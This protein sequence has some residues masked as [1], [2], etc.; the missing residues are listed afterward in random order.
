MDCR[1]RVKAKSQLF[2]FLKEFSHLLSRG[3]VSLYLT[4]VAMNYGK[5]TIRLILIFSLYICIGL[6]Q[7]AKAAITYFGSSSNPADGGSGTSQ[8][9]AV[10]PPSNM[11]VGDLVIFTGVH[12]SW[13][14]A[15]DITISNT[16]GQSWTGLTM[17]TEAY[18]RSRIFYAR[19]DGTW[20]AN[21]SIYFS[22]KSW[23]GTDSMGVIMHVFRPTYTCKEWAMDVN[24]VYNE[25]SDDPTVI[26]GITTNTNGALVFAEWNSSGTGTWGSLTSG[27]STPG[28]AQYRNSGGTLYGI[29]A[30][31]AYKVQAT[32]GATGNVSKDNSG[33]QDG[34][35]HIMAFKE[36]TTLNN[37]VGDGTDPSNSTIAPGTSATEIDRFTLQASSGTDTI[38]GATVTLGPTGAYNNIATVAIQNTAGTTTYCTT[39]TITSNTVSMTCSGF[40][41]TTTSTAYKIMITPKTHASMPAV[42]G[43]SYATTAT[44]TG[45]TECYNV[46]GSDTDSATITV[47]NA[48]PGAVTSATAYADDGSVTLGWTNPTDADFTTGGTTI[49]LRR[50]GSAISDTPVEGTTY[51]VG[52]TIGSSTVMAVYTGS[53]P[54]TGYVNSSLTNGTVYYYKIFTQDSRGNYNAGTSPTGSP[55]SPRAPAEFISVIDPGNGSGTDYTS[56]SVWEST[57]QA[58]ITSNSVVFFPGT[59]TGTI[60]NGASVTGAT[61]GATGT[62]IHANAAG[63][64]IMLTVTSGFFQSGE[65][66]RVDASNYFTT[67]GILNSVIAIAKCRTTTA[68]ADTTAVTLDGWTTRSANYIKIWT[69]TS[70]N[71]RHPGNWD[72]SKYRLEVS[73][74][75]AIRI[76]EEYTRI[77]GLQIQ[78]SDSSLSYSGIV[79]SPSTSTTNLRVAG[80]IIKGDVSGTPQNNAGIIQSSNGTSYVWNNVVYGFQYGIET[81]TSGSVMYAYNNTVY[82]NHTGI[83]NSTASAITLKNSISYKNIGTDYSGTFNS[84][85][86]NNLSEDATVPNIGTYYSNTTVIFADPENGDFHLYSSDTGAKN[87]GTSSI[88]EIG[89]TV[90]IDNVTRN[91]TWD[92]GADEAATQV[93]YSVGQNNDDHKTGS[94]TVTISSGVA[95]FS[96]AQTAV[97]MGVG[98]KVTYNTSSVAYISKKI[99]DITWELVTA[100]GSAPADVSGQTVNSIAHTFSSLYAAEDGADDASY[101]NTSNLVS[102]NYQLNISCYYDSGADATAVTVDGWTTG[103]SNYIRIYTPNNTLSEVNQSQ[104]H[105]GSLNTARYMLQLSAANALTISEEYVRVDGL[106]IQ[107]T[108]T[109]STYSGIIISPATSVANI[110]ISNNII[111]GVASGTAQNSRGIYQSSDGTSY[112]WNNIVHGFKNGTNTLYGIETNSSGSV[113][114]A[115]NNTAYGN[116]IGLYPAAGTIVAKNNLSYNNT[117]DY[118]GTFNSASTNNLSKDATVPNLGTYYASATVIFLNISLEDYRLS[119]DDTGAKDRGADLGSGFYND[120]D[121]NPRSSVWDIGADE[122]WIVTFQSEKQQEEGNR[123]GLI[124]YQSF[125]GQDISGTKAID[126]SGNGYDGTISGA[127]AVI[128]KKGQ[129]L[130]FDGADDNIDAGSDFIGI[131]EGTYSAWIFPESIG[132]TAG[133]IFDNGKTFISLGTNIIVFSSDGGTNNSQSAVSSI[134]YNK[135]SF[136]S[137]TRDSSGLTN[138][139]IDGVL[140]GTADQNSGTPVAGTS[141]VFIGNTSDA[142]R[143]FDGII[144]EVRIYSRIL[145]AEE[146]GDL[147]RLGEAKINSPQATNSNNGLILSQSFDGRYMDWS[148]SSAEARDASGNAHH[149]DVSG[150]IATIGR[151][152]QALSFDG[153]DDYVSQGNVSSGIKTIAFWIKADNVV[154]KKIIDIDGTDQIEINASS[155]ITATSFPGYTTVYVDGAAGST[156]DTNWHFV[157]ITDVTGVNASANYLGR[158]GSSYFDGILDE[159]RF[160]NRV[161]SST[162]VADLYRL[163]QVKI[164]K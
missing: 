6:F 53:P 13:T 121:G 128:G 60:A 80:N 141:H 148:L 77:E 111:K 55:A 113:M 162:E 47:D 87:K 151:R 156:I 72:T 43:A 34:N 15:P 137:V 19:F 65:Q 100:T 123:S 125:N 131:S 102:G 150:A 149:G 30:T 1:S 164:S 158:V 143:T 153:T 138:I 155:Q 124:F 96:V 25:Y 36:T 78:V 64:Q 51:S 105:Q 29:S 45:L 92:I 23:L 40:S 160:Y 119:M 97:N 14:S 134:E 161:L 8:T 21:P 58:D 49:V 140:S 127:T 70:E 122:A 48:S 12:S 88:S 129:A 101:L 4:T 69:D 144:D 54:T 61:S 11:Q 139:Y 66:I 142:S 63:T 7:P 44:V 59:K 86:T 26:S 154:S 114:Y 110:K 117:T 57:T 98:D 73:G 52:N 16:G 115:Y 112:V 84:A 27:W 68:A 83:Y 130:S 32:A 136:I 103:S 118:S 3:K 107:L 50:V 76:Y 56:L 33:G 99:S 75:N 18:I 157:T 147:Y 85:S 120:I 31:A 146:V 9:T 89:F 39:S 95:T 17:V 116:Y 133:R 5:I 163:G 82:E 145:S 38:Y 94:P 28:S 22:E 81:T 41:A 10:T 42:P 91:G 24:E 106:Q 132:E 35:S 62:V 135:W 71:Y 20:D 109:S 108:V 2:N 74:N 159:V 93:F 90:D 152:G 46:I 126:R 37:T 79:L 104:R 67:S